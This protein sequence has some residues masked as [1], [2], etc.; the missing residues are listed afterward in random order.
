MREALIQL[1]S[2]GLIES[3]THRGSYVAMTSPNDVRD[4]YNIF[5]L[6]NGLA[7]ERAAKTISAESLA[8]LELTCEQMEA[9]QDPVALQD[10]NVEYHRLV[11]RE[12]GSRRMLAVLRYLT[13]SLPGR[14]YEFA[15][16]WDEE[17][18]GIT[19]R[20][21]SYFGPVT[22]K[23]QVARWLSTPGLG[24]RSLCNSS[25]NAA[26]GERAVGSRR[27]PFRFSYA[28]LRRTCYND[29]TLNRGQRSVAAAS[30]SVGPA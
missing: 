13:N 5:G 8:S 16:G 2:E 9:S 3:K 14:F 1:E 18:T 11:N 29:S 30:A 6:V 15:T 20:F 10:L 21:S 12:G 17:P 7:A 27:G 4:H 28:S 22:L 19:V 24:P 26:S 23:G 25:K